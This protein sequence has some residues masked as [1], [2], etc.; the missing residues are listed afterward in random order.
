MTAVVGTTY[1][2]R[3]RARQYHPHM[4]PFALRSV[5]RPAA[6]VAAALVLLAVATALALRGAGA[7]LRTAAEEALQARLVPRVLIAEPVELLLLPQPA[8]TLREVSLHE[9]SGETPLAVRELTLR[10]DP[11]ALWR[12]EVAVATLAVSGVELALRRD[13]T[14]WNA[15]QW[16]RPDADD[17]GGPTPP[18]GRIVIEGARIRIEG[19][20]PAQIEL[21][22]LAAGPFIPGASGT[23]ALAGR[24]AGDAAALELGAEA[25]YRLDADGAVSVDAV[26]VNADGRFAQ[27][28]LSAARLQLGAL[29]RGPGAALQADAASVTLTAAAPPTTVELEAR[30]AQWVGDGTRWRGTGLALTLQAGHEAHRLSAN[31]TS[32][33]AEGD[34]DSWRLPQV[35]IGLATQA[36]SP[37]LALELAG[38]LAGEMVSA[39]PSLR[40]AIERAQARLPHPA[41]G[42]TPLALSFA[43]AAHLD[44]VR[45]VADGTLGGAFDNSR[46]DGAWRF[47]AAAAPPLALSA[48]L[49]RIDLDRY[50]PPPA[51]DPA[52]ADLAAWHNWPVTADLRIGRLR[53]GGFTADNARLRLS[54]GASVTGAR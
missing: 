28:R 31:L 5:R 45:L 29:R 24:A 34:A 8:L 25:R 6:I 49:D 44:P 50:L 35:T 39:A 21:T 3:R 53:A 48:S 20:F 12:G 10:L 47:D 13:A 1:A 22:R 15:L 23:L 36:P 51:A 9:A 11:A 17:A 37:P 30:L 16:L 18:I 42:A 32:P 14:G 43:G 54:G 40:L 41:G 33:A 52:P 46:F 19:D 27:W 2:A 38:E 7:W 4:N 26:Q